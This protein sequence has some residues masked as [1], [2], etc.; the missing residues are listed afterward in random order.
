[1]DSTANQKMLSFMYAY[2]RYIQIRMSQTDEE[3]NYIRNIPSL[4]CKKV[5]PFKLKELEEPIRGWWIGCSRSK[6]VRIWKFTSM[7][8]LWKQGVK[9]AYCWFV[10]DQH[11]GSYEST[12]WIST[13]LN[14]PLGWSQKIF[15]ASQFW[16]GNLR[17]IWRRLGH[18][19]HEAP[20]NPQWG[21]DVCRKN[22]NA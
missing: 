17:L 13:P 21:V 7:N 9:A 16:K 10:R 22:H 6:L 3:K 8:H 2:F 5:K 14:V 12:R 15:L 11:L 18:H 20:Q 19:H 4:Q 1:M